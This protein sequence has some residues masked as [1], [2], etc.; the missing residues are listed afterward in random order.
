M[1]IFLF[2][3]NSYVP[4]LFKLEETRGAHIFNS[5]YDDNGENI[6]DK[7]LDYQKKQKKK[8]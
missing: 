2:V 7:I 3:L 8:T 6:I 5:V 1:R 4:T